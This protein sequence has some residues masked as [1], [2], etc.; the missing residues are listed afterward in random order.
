MTDYNGFISFKVDAL[1]I[2]GRLTSGGS[3]VAGATIAL[4]S[5]EEIEDVKTDI[6]EKK[7]RG[8]LTSV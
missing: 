5:K 1:T 7:V 6:P 2:S 8:L 3:G 4:N